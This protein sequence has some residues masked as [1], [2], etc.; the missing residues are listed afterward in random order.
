[1]CV[2]VRLFVFGLI[3][4]MIK[5]EFVHVQC[6]IAPYKQINNSDNNNQTKKKEKQN[7]L[8]TCSIHPFCV[9]NKINKN[10]YLELNVI[11]KLQMYNIKWKKHGKT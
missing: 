8:E 7:D 5:T 10:K 4:C 9:Y 2:C 11:A 3:V 1:M 6:A